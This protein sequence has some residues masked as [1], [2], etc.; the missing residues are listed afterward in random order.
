MKKNGQK[1]I[2]AV[3]CVVVIIGLFWYA[4]TKKV[5]SAEN[6]DNLTEVQKVITKNL[7]KNYP[8]TPREVVKFYNRIIKV[9]HNT[10]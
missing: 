5:N 4:T 2:F 3:V 9:I 1:I 10:F 6:S 7:E 8:E